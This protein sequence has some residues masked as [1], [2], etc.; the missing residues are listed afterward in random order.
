MSTSFYIRAINVGPN[1]ESVEFNN[2]TLFEPIPGNWL[3]GYLQDKYPLLSMTGSGG[4]CGDVSD[5]INVEHGQE[6]TVAESLT[7]HRALLEFLN[8][9][10]FDHSF[11]RHTLSAQFSIRELRAMVEKALHLQI[12]MERINA[13]VVFTVSWS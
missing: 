2:T 6:T 9:E 12:A 10:V 13:D 4:T 5:P 1:R 3:V 8:N 11:S 7:T